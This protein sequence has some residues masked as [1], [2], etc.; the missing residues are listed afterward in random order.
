MDDSERFLLVEDGG[1]IHA[2]LVALLGCCRRVVVER[3]VEGALAALAGCATWVAIV[4]DSELPDG[5]GLE[6]LARARATHPTTPTLLTAPHVDLETITASYRYD[7]YFAPKP[8]ATERLEQFVRAAVPFS[9]RLRLV[10]GTWNS[11]HGLSNAEHDILVRAACG[12]SRE[13]IAA[14]RD[15]SALTVKKHVANLLQKT[16]DETLL[17]AVARLLREASGAT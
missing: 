7:A 8:L 14:A 9:M 12:A 1:C 4:I 15:S 3:T 11:R 13:D 6:I 16:G 5:C 10:A 17:A 2:R